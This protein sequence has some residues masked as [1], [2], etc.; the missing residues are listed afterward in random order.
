MPPIILTII[1]LSLL[2]GF[3]NGLNDSRNVISTLVSSRAYSPR[4]ALGVTILAEFSGP[5]IFGTAVAGTIG[6][7]IA[8]PSAINQHVILVALVSAIFWNLFSW[9][10]KIPSSSSH[11][12]I[13]GIVGA[14]SA[15]AGVAAVQMNGLLKILV[16]LFASPIIGFIF[17]FIALK[18]IFALCLDSNPGVNRFFKRSQIVTA[19]A[20]GLSHGSNDG[21]KTM[22]IVTL[23]LVTGGYLGLFQ[24]PLWVMAICAGALTFGTLIGGL[25]LIRRPGGSFYKIR[26]VDGFSTQVTAAV[27]VIGASLVGG[28]VSATQVINTAIMGVGAAERAN[29]VR[30]GI[31]K[32]IVMAWILTIP[33]TALVSAGMYRLMLYGIVHYGLHFP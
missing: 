13:G 27:T 2:F 24:V 19:L 23:A 20:L 26:P 14:V 12:L 33:A 28:P 15:G 17:G 10:M 30:W 22:G 5:F 25:L 9:K 32:D 6:R 31:A 21:Q 3:L 1:G 11:A 8:V 16:S 4:V 7:G 29:K 18:I